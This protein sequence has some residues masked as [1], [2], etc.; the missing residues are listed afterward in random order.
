MEWSLVDNSRAPFGCNY[1]CAQ[2]W[3]VWR[4]ICHIRSVLWCLSWAEQII[5]LSWA[6][7]HTTDSILLEKPKV[8][9]RCNCTCARKVSVSRRGWRERKKTVAGGAKRLTWL[10]RWQLDNAGVCDTKNLPLRC[11]FYV[12]MNIYWCF[13]CWYCTWRRHGFAS[14]CEIFITLPTH[15]HMHIQRHTHTSTH[16]QS[17]HKRNGD[18]QAQE[19]GWKGRKKGFG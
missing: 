12:T 8:P 9:F 17:A 4:C 15:F 13:L 1:L 2:E 6:N 18:S 14:I 11:L 7:K 16:I 19:P 10:R 5:V 3:E